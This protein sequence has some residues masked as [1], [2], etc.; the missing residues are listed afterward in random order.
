[1][2]LNEDHDSTTYIPVQALG[3]D[4]P[5]VADLHFSHANWKKWLRDFGK[6][7]DTVPANKV[8]WAY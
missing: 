3:M 2:F 8:P 4:K 5:S 7:A 1:M 6:K